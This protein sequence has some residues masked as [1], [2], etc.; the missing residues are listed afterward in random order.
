MVNG[1]NSI[2]VYVLVSHQEFWSCCC[3]P[4]INHCGYTYVNNSYFACLKVIMVNVGDRWDT[5]WANMHNNACNMI[6]MIHGTAVVPHHVPFYSMCIILTSPCL[7]TADI[8]LVKMPKCEFFL[9]CFCECSAEISSY[10]TD[11]GFENRV[12][13]I[14]QLSW[15]KHHFS[16][17]RFRPAAND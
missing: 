12:L 3:T 11:E 6:L 9:F 16:N 17:M 7:Q 5:L 10:L 15:K 13:S 1:A 4:A 2:I 8:V 14:S